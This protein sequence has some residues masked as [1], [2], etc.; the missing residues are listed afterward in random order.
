MPAAWTGTTPGWS[1][2]LV[3]CDRD[4]NVTVTQTLH[5][6]NGPEI[7]AKLAGADGKVTQWMDSGLSDNAI[8]DEMYLSTLSRYPSAK[9]KDQL[10]TRV[11]SAKLKREVWEDLLWAMLSSKEF[12]F[13][14]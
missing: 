4:E 5:S 11:G 1:S 6:L 10:L 8:L 12:Q 7:Q 2:R 3:I 9:E 13:N 14:H